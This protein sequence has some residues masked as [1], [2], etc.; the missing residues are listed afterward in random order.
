MSN[1]TYNLG[2]VG[3]NL[4][5]EYAG[6]TNYEK[7]DVVTREGSSYAA[8]QATVNIA[9][10]NENYWMLLSRGVHSYG[11]TSN[12][13]YVKF[14][15][16]NGGLMIEGKRVVTTGTQQWKTWAS[17]N[18]YADIEMG[19]W[20]IEFETLWTVIPSLHKEQLSS[21]SVGS[22]VAEATETSAGTIRV[23]HGTGTA[24]PGERT[25]TVIGIGTWQ[26]A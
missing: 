14:G 17:Y 5:G 19:D 22:A 21:L 3:L 18:Y 10:P 1:E 11:T 4:R 6:G 20:D 25:Y 24:S 2:R 7:L 12:G 23:G 15:D 26:A 8:K 9:P 16:E 13:W